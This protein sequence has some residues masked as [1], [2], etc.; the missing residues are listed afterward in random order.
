[1][2]YSHII[3]DFNGTILNDVEA[4]I[5]SIN[6]LLSKRGLK[7]VD[8]I[9]YYHSKFTFPI[10][11]YYESLGFD[12]EKYPYDEL[13]VEWVEQYIK[14]S[15]TS[16]LYPGVESTMKKLKQMGYA[17]II[18]SATESDM[19]E[20]QI[21]N[22]GIDKYIDGFFGLGDIYAHSKAELVRQW[23]M[24]NPNAKALAVG[25]TVH[26]YEC[27]SAANIDC[28]LVA[29]GHQSK[30]SLFQCGVEVIDDISHLIKSQTLN[31]L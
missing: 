24:S 27:A 30:E 25:D 3:W 11:K 21:L 16:E 20:K 31:S 17:Q 7:T 23:A 5:K 22:L 4:G 8:N 28:I 12:F 10:S 15:S 18:L 2:K 6:Y 9:E 1:M 29:G 19:L 13:A 14:N 26:D